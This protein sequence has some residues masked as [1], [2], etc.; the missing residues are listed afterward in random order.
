MKDMKAILDNT[1][2]MFNE[3]SAEETIDAT[4]KD[5]IA[6]LK[7]VNILFLALY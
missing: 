4:I 1:V 7:R 5:E 3:I 2:K 6:T